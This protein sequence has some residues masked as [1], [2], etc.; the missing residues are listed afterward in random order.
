MQTLLVCMR[1]SRGVVRVIIRGGVFR[2]L[3]GKIGILVEKG[4]YGGKLWGW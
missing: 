2:R 4:G 3:W 1:N